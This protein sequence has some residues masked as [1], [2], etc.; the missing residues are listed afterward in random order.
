MNF[1]ENLRV[2]TRL[3]RAVMIFAVLFCLA[4]AIGTFLIGKT[5]F[6][7]EDRRQMA[8]I[9]QEEY[10]RDI[11]YSY[12]ATKEFAAQR[13]RSP[14]LLDLMAN[15]GTSDTIV[16]QAH[17]D[18]SKRFGWISSSGVMIAV[19]AAIAAS[20]FAACGLGWV[21]RA[22]RNLEKAGMKMKH[23]AIGAV[24]VFLIPL[25][26]LV[27]PSEAMR[28]LYNR[29]HGEPPELANSEADDVRAWFFAYFCG[30]ILVSLV[31]FK[32]VYDAA[33]PIVILTPYWMEVVMLS[34][35]VIL[36]LLGVILFAF[37][38][39]KIT[40][41]QSEL[42]YSLGEPLAERD[43]KSSNLPRVTLSSD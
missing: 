5:V 13:A 26:N 6:A 21:W 38:A 8:L 4:S 28:E 42:L 16:V 37:L 11:G 14:N 41:A 27:L 43:Q 2:L 36:I 3:S 23:S 19:F 24:T 25:L 9:E 33:N 20:G 1:T 35:A 39:R 40:A 17:S 30:L 18:E 7:A 29:S 12:R 32:F 15:Y 31:L 22:Y 10:M 34:F